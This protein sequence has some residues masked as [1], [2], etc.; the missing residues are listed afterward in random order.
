MALCSCGRQGELQGGWKDRGTE[1]SRRC[2][3]WGVT[4]GS[5]GVARR[6]GAAAT[7]GGARPGRICDAPVR[8]S[9][10]CTGDLGPL[11]SCCCYPYSLILT[12]NKTQN[13][14]LLRA[15]SSSPSA[16]HFTW[17]GSHHLGPK[18][19]GENLGESLPSEEGFDNKEKSEAT[20]TGC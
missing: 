2:K 5:W 7:R 3:G 16:G 1:G 15:Q 8:V 6:K 18:A 13:R 9:P 11:E 4:Q 19:K 20:R 14:F 10:H 12:M 17:V